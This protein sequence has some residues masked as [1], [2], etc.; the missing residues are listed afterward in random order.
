MGTRAASSGPRPRW[1][2]RAGTARRPRPIS[3]TTPGHQTTSAYGDIVLAAEL[4]IRA[5]FWRNT[6][7]ALTCSC[8]R[9]RKKTPPTP[10]F[11]LPAPQES[12]SAYSTEGHRAALHVFDLVPDRMA[13]CLPPSLDSPPGSSSHGT[14]SRLAGLHETHSAALPRGR[15]ERTAAKP[16]RG[17]QNRFMKVSGYAVQ[18]PRPIWPRSALVL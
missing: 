5:D 2:L 17:Q 10:G 6:P 1:S 13:S 11:C 16:A 7:V 12:P 15:R 3:F 4:P 14:H 18:D 8:L 9:E